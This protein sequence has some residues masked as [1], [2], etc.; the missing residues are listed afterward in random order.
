MDIPQGGFSFSLLPDRIGSRSWFLEYCSQ[1][2]FLKRGSFLMLRK[3]LL[4]RRVEAKIIL[5]Y[6]II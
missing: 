2:I 3:C 1:T 5:S 6:D 4:T